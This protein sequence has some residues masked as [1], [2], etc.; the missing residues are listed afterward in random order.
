[1]LAE[2]HQ[3]LQSWTST[4]K[5]SM[6]E[7]F[8]SKSIEFTTTQYSLSKMEHNKNN[9]LYSQA[10]ELTPPL[11]PAH[12]PHSTSSLVLAQLNLEIR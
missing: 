11:K 3:L 1:M 4:E 8:F 12:D 9:T 10:D 2:R 5:D 6:S 7:I